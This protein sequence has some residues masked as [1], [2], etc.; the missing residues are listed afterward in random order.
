MAE[1]VGQHRI[2]VIA[3]MAHL[4]S[5]VSPLAKIGRNVTIG[6]FCL[7]QPEVEIHDRC[8]L[9]ANVVIK[10]DTTLGPNNHVFEGTTLA[11][12]VVVDPEAIRP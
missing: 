2:E 11:G 3:M 9:E 5:C 4:A 10:N 8:T 6:P 7:V 1:A 12:H